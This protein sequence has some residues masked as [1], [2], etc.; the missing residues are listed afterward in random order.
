MSMND[1]LAAAL[2][3]ILNGERI[4]QKK[5][6]IKPVSSVIKQIL[7]IMQE[8]HY[9]GGATEE[10]DG[11]GGFLN[12]A[13]MG[14]INKCGAIKPRFSVKITDYEKWEKRFLPAKDFGI[15]IMSTPKGIMTHIE[16]KTRKL[17][18]RLLAYCY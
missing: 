3:K 12:L 17:G 4:G 2:S 10:E 9:T 13:L 7:Q 11:M 16:A 18:G 15:L 6:L 5:C 1:T 14:K 8:Q